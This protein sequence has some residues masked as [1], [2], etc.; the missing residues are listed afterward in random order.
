[1][2]EFV[3]WSTSGPV[4]RLGVE[5]RFRVQALPTEAGVD[6]DQ[7]HASTSKSQLITFGPPGLG[8]GAGVGASEVLVEIT[9]PEYANTTS[10][11]AIS[12][13]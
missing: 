13:R 9:A 8:V 3:V 7:L 4:P 5:P 12:P 1:V 11:I 6:S 10:S 2:P